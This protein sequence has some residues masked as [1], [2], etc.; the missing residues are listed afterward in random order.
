MDKK[1]TI[2]IIDELQELLFVLVE[3]Y[4][5]CSASAEELESLTKL[6]ELIILT[7]SNPRL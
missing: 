1:S 5:R 2:K 7:K 6:A 3:R 4:K